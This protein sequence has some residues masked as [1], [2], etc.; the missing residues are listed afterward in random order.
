MSN[1]FMSC[2]FNSARTLATSFERTPVSRMKERNTWATVGELYRYVNSVTAR[3]C[4]TECKDIKLQYIH[5]IRIVRSCVGSKGIEK[6][7]SRFFG[8]F[9]AEKSLPSFTNFSTFGDKAQPPEIHVR[10]T[11]YGYETFFLP[12]QTL[13]DDIPLETS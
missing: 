1:P 10:A 9:D 2:A 6:L 8:N 4:I 13:V 7:P 5:A 12:N 11:H 3:G